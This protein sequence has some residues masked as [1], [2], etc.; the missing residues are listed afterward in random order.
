M[1]AELIG[2]LV[3]LGSGGAV[4]AIMALLKKASIKVETLN[5]R[6]KQAIVLVS[7]YGVVK[8]NGLLGLTLPVDVL[9]WGADS[10]N[11]LLTAGI[12]FGSYNVFKI[13]KSA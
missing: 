11:T 4:T 13:R 10:V 5:P 9:G 8:L 6:V 12:S 3:A 7:S 2:S 1:E